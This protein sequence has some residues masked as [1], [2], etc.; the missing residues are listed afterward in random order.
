MLEVLRQDYVRTARAKGLPERTVIY[1]HAFRNAL[2]PLVTVIGVSI[3]LLVT[4]AF[5]I[6]RT[7]N[8]PGIAETTLGAIDYRDYPVIQ[9]TTVLLAV[10]VV[11][12]NLLSDIL[13]TL[14]D[15][16]I[17]VE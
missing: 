4:G 10:A 2:I 1:W 11:L 7:F 8:I 14:V 12:G 9:A 15:P 17:K 16:R 13:Y 6:E 3:G 5:F